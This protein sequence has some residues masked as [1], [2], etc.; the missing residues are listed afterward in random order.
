MQKVNPI[1]SYKQWGF[2]LTILIHIMIR[3][4][5]VQTPDLQ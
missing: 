3:I 4:A 5:L 2:K 1:V